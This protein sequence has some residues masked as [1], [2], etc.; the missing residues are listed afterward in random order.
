MGAN[1]QHVTPGQ[2]VK[3]SARRENDITDLLNAMNGASSGSLLGGAGALSRVKI[4]NNTSEILEQGTPVAFD[5]GEI[6][7]GSIPARQFRKGDQIFGVLSANLESGAFGSA[8][9]SGP[10]EIEVSEGTSGKY[11]NP[12]DD[13]KSF[14]LGGTGVQVLAHHEKTAVILLG[15]GGSQVKLVQLTSVPPIGFGAGTAK[16]VKGFSDSGAV[17]LEE[18]EIP[19]IIPGI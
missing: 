16:V 19:V 13:G 7:D 9:I 11:A 3:H 8:V 12:S 15:G 2:R 17:V 1:Y 6:I 18:E 10:V 4:Y 14:V 5:D